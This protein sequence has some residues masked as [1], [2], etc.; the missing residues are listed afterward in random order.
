MKN[1]EL[2]RKFLDGELNEADEQQ[3]L[4]IIADTPEM[5]ELL[6]F[7]R[8]LFQTFNREPDPESF[9]V[10]EHFSES[11]M[12]Q[13]P[14]REPERSSSVFDSVQSWLA[15]LLAPRPLVLR[16]VYVMAAILLVAGGLGYS[17]L[18]M[19]PAGQNFSG[20]EMGTSTQTVAET[21]SEIWI[22][23]VYFDDEA[24]QIEVAGDFSDWEP[25]PLDEEVV[26][27]RR[28]WTGLVPITRGEHRYMFVKDGVEWV[29]DP[30]AS[31]Q[32]DDGF[33]NKNAVLYL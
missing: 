16:P 28:V 13:L 22:R 1:E 21:E 10:P 14:L 8:T 31:V 29:T 4:H 32:R 12:K 24:E 3:A 5:R 27:G 9:E 6:R 33:G 18:T 15:D 20:S 26:D 30:L 2:F 7:E 23:F 11:V 19:Q 25:V 17:L